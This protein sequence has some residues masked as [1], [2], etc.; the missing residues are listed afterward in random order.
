MTHEDCL[1]QDLTD[2]PD[3]LVSVYCLFPAKHST[4]VCIVV[5][6]TF[7]QLGHFNII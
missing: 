2:P 3:L 1:F 4:L 7:I 5:Y 6:K